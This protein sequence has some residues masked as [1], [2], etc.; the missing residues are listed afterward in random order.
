VHLDAS[1]SSALRPLWSGRK[2]LVDARARLRQQAGALVDWLWPGFSATD[3]QAGSLRW[4]ATRSVPRPAE[5]W[6]GCWPRAGPRPPGRDQRGRAGGGVRAR[7]WRLSRPMANRL[8]TRAASALAAIQPP[9]SASRPPWRPCSTPWLPWTARS[10]GWRPRW[11][12]CWPPPR[13]PSS[14]RSAGW[15]PSPRPD[16]SPW[17]ATPAAG[18]RGPRCGGRPGWTRPAANPAPATQ[19]TASAGKDRRGAAGDP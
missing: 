19:A 1:P 6:W 8:L 15:P 16:W 12:R 7:G 17:W 3:K 4:S 13:A 14:P 18:A 5:W 11:P 10:L 9:P 2:D